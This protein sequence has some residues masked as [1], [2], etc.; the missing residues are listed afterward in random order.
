MPLLSSIQL[1]FSGSKAIRKVIALL[2]VCLLM[3]SCAITNEPINSASATQMLSAENYESGQIFLFRG[4]PLRYRSY[5]DFFPKNEIVNAIEFLRKRHAQ[6]FIISDESPHTVLF[7]YGSKIRPDA[8]IKTTH[9]FERPTQMYSPYEFYY[10][11]KELIEAGTPIVILNEVHAG[12]Y[13]GNLHFRL[14]IDNIEV[15][16]TIVPIR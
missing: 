16:K 7:V 1:Q 2:T 10:D 13:G 14:L 12:G 8:S 9:Q 6:D 3:V 11:S 4:E 5:L 15:H